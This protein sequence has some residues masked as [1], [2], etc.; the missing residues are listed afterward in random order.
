M[1]DLFDHIILCNHCHSPTSKK[2]FIKDGFQIRGLECV[3]CNTFSY[4]PG[5]VKDYEQFMRLKARAFDVKLR[6]VGNSFCIS[7]P[8]EI[9]AFHQLENDL[10]Q[11]VHLFLQEPDKLVL[12]FHTNVYKSPGVKA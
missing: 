2:V 9:I 5:D 3:S 8:K 4:H 6:M 7:I 10:D 1:E 11:L 12:E